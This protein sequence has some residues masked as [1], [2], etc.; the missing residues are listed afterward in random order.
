MNKR[1]SLLE[2]V[3]VTQEHLPR[4]KNVMQLD[5]TKST[6]VHYLTF[7]V[8]NDGLLYVVLQQEDDEYRTLTATFYDDQEKI[9]GGVYFATGPELKRIPMPEEGDHGES[10]PFTGDCTL[11]IR[12]IGEVY[13]IRESSTRATEDV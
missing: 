13:F 11:P 8:G 2:G 5:L 12:E 9:V 6:P 1:K 7:I 4:G 10:S 3:G